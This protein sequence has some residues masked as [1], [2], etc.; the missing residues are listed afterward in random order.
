M[1]I[2]VCGIH[3]VNQW[4][5]E[6]LYRHYFLKLVLKR[7]GLE[8]PRVL[9]RVILAMFHLHL[10]SHLS[11]YEIDQTDIGDSEYEKYKFSEISMVEHIE[12]CI[13]SD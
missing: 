11:I 10:H 5:G 7:C 9:F 3:P 8:N 6:S 1:T 4:H 2:W 13:Q 12:W